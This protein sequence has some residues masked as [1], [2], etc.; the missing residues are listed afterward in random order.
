[1]S[2]ELSRLVLFLKEKQLLALKMAAF[3][4]KHKIVL[5]EGRILYGKKK[6][7]RNTKQKNRISEYQSD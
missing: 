1:M 4:L 3:H 2:L 5:I 6:Q 7:Q